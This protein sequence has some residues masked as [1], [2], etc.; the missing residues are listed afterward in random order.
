MHHA[1]A[2]RLRGRGVIGKEQFSGAVESN[3]SQCRRCDPAQI[4]IS[5]DLPAPLPPT[6][7]ITSELA[8]AKSTSALASVGPKALVIPCNSTRWVPRP[9]APD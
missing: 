9:T 2:T 1:D 8:T 6:S 5:V 4:R 7:P 3:L